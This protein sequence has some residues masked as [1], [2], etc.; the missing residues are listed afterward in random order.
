[1]AFI[2]KT[3]FLHSAGGYSQ[4]ME[5]L[6]NRQG[7]SPN[8]KVLDSSA[9]PLNQMRTVFFTVPLTPK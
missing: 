6:W 8:W 9:I 5:E 2:I 3:T 4:A 7:K 1:M